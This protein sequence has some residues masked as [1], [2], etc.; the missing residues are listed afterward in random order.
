MPIVRSL[1]NF[2]GVLDFVNDR[3]VVIDASEAG[4]LKDKQISPTLLNR[5]IVVLPYMAAGAPG[6]SHDSTLGYRVGNIGLDTSTGRLYVCV[7]ATAA[8]AV[9]SPL[10]L[11][12]EIERGPTANRPPASSMGLSILFHDTTLG[13][14]I[15][16]DGTTWVNVDGT[17]L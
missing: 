11:P 13:K 8:A 10:H 7:D 5:Q 6:A 2:T 12:G 14:V 9:W 3:L 16:H 17:S 15:L 1:P 4:S